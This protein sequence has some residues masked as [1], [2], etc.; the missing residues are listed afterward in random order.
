[1]R[2]TKLLSY[3][4]KGV[5][6]IIATYFYCKVLRINHIANKFRDKTFWVLKLTQIK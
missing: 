3:S 6:I 4:N 5:P 1:M 2:K